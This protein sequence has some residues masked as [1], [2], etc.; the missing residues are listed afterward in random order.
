[1]NSNDWKTLLPLLD[2]CETPNKRG[3]LSKRG[4][5]EAFYECITGQLAARMIYVRQDFSVIGHTRR[6][7]LK[8]HCPKCMSSGNIVN[9]R[10]ADFLWMNRFGGLLGGGSDGMGLKVWV[11]TCESFEPPL[12]ASRL[13]KALGRRDG[14]Y[15]PM[16]A[17]KWAGEVV[18]ID[19][20]CA[21]LEATST[22]NGPKLGTPFIFSAL[23]FSGPSGS[24]DEER[25]RN[26]LP[27]CRIDHFHGCL[28]L[29]WEFYLRRWSRMQI[30]APSVAEVA[31]WV[32]RGKRGF[33]AI[34][35]LYGKKTN[36]KGAYLRRL[37]GES[38]NIV[39]VGCVSEHEDRDKARER[40]RQNL[41]GTQGWDLHGRFLTEREIEKIM[42]RIE[43][44]LGYAKGMS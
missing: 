12:S 3:K 37:R 21:E 26:L 10:Q 22:P 25:L 18:I 8:N 9:L 1:M 20:T 15:R 28:A 31:D 33:T 34:G 30:E 11:V 27:G 23:L 35:A 7:Q 2:S 43:V 40:I 17:G 5:R 42:P 38:G 14:R 29:A 24:L 19:P 41:Q 13:S 36:E 16:M 6:C 32:N 4:K 44:Q 39:A